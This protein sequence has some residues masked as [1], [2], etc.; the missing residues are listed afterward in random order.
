LKKRIIFVSLILILVS[1]L[2]L[3]INQVAAEQV[4][5]IENY[6]VEMEINSD[7]DF[8]ITEEIE[9][10][11]IEGE[12]STAYREVPGRGFAGI[13]FIAIS[14][15]DRQLIDYNV[16][17]GSSLEV[18]WE[19]PETTGLATF[20]I[21]YAGRA[22]LIS[23]DGRNILDW[24]ALGTDWDV[25]VENARVR[26]SL[27]EEPD[28]IE[29]ID[30]GEPD[31]ISYSDLYFERENIEPGEGWRINFSFSEQI[32]MPERV[33]IQDYFAWLI[34]LLIIALILVIYRIVDSYKLMKPDDNNMKLLDDEIIQYNN[35]SFPEKLLLHDYKGAK[36][37]RMLAALIFYLG[38]LNLIQLRVDIKDKFFGGEKAEIKLALPEEMTETEEIDDL[39]VLSDL[40]DE[41]G[42]NEKKLEKVI[43]KSSLWR[44]I[45]DK[46]KEKAVVKAWTS[47]YRKSIR[48]TSLL[49][50]LL[51][52][53][54]SI[55]LFLDFVINDRVITFLPAVF[56]GLLAIGEFIRY[57]VILP[58]TDTAIK[59]REKITNEID[60]RRERLEELVETD[61]LAALKLILSNL[62]W[63]LVDDKMTGSKF[64]KY[65]KEIEKNI[66]D[67][68]AESL[69][70]PH[71]LAVDGLEGALKAIEVVEYTMTAVY[72]AVA[73]T[74]ASS[75]GAGGGAGGGGGGAG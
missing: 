23:S 2:S 18:D 75:G 59:M 61:S 64:K 49:I 50:G 39:K 52:I 8:I 65:R 54:I 67:K 1:V 21:E 33:S 72:A 6:L 10:N 51:L 34:G 60:E 20:R 55:G 71:W 40:F 73:S 44:K 16:S 42:D 43:T 37:A 31:S 28:G 46:Y 7:G 68:E 38:K 45:V 3:N 32:T 19:Y 5:R 74:S 25:P 58:L 26:I 70:V 29:F 17:D 41:I 48:S 27:L 24:Q 14:S 53:A 47:D 66:S 56:T 15:V 57:A 69:E 36:G 12:F 35:L 22:G 62:A 13:D 30:G 11:F 4:Y 63:L 9:Y